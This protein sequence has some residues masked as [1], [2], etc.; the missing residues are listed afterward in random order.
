MRLNSGDITGKVS[1]LGALFSLSAFR[2]ALAI[3]FLWLFARLLL[4]RGCAVI[5]AAGP[6]KGGRAGCDITIAQATKKT[7]T[8]HFLFMRHRTVQKLPHI[9]FQLSRRVLFDIHHVPSPVELP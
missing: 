8:N 9:V 1:V 7:E 2:S 5:R 4:N 6:T 3:V